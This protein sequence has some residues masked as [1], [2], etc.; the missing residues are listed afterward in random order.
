MRLADARGEGFVVA[1]LGLSCSVDIVIRGPY[2]LLST[3]V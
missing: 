2:I 1:E 3:H